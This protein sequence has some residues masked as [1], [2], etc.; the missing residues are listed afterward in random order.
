[1][2]TELIV[3]LDVPRIEDVPPILSRLPAELTH[4]KVGLELFIREGRAAVAMLSGQ[5]KRIFLDLKLHDIP[6]TVA[7][8]VASAAHLDVAL[9][10]L[11][12]SGGKAMIHAAAEAARDFGPRAPKLIAVTALTSLDQSDLVDLGI[13]RTVEA[14]TL[15]LAD[16]ALSSGAD[17]LVASVHEAAALRAR[18]GSDFLLVTPGIR[19]AGTQ[20]GDQKRI[21][22]P[23]RAV[24]AGANF[25]VVGRPI[26]D[27]PDPGAVARAILAEMGKAAGG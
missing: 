18:F 3:A 15:A 22:T 16:L 14:H 1:M 23:A 21:A 26:L 6:R 25:I 19:P 17:G 12:A 27:A 8:A 20:A 5:H 2:T 11:H 4:F 24:E 13:Q 10:T 9:L 7:H